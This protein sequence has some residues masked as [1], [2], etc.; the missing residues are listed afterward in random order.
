MKV[1][2]Y[3]NSENCYAYLLEDFLG[4]S[5]FQRLSG[6]SQL[7]TGAVINTNC[8]SNLYV[9]IVKSQR[10]KFS[11]RALILNFLS[12]MSIFTVLRLTFHI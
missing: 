9:G 11:L 12:L 3:S 8:L 6:C 10:K 4:L 7:R 1:P 5:N 2:I